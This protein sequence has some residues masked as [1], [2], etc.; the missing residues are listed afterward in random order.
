MQRN[1]EG[2]S[3]GAIIMSIATLHEMLTY[4][5]PDGSRSE[6]EFIERYL[7]PLGCKEDKFGN[8]SKSIGPAPP[9]LWSSHTDTVH[10]EDGRQSVEVSPDGWIHGTGEDCLGADC[11]AGVWLMREMIQRKVPGLYVF[12]RAEETGGRGSS[13]IAKHRAKSL[14]H[15]K[16]AI[17]LDR[18]GF[19]SIIT[20]Q[21]GGRCCSDAFASS[22]SAAMQENSWTLDTGGIFT[23]TANYTHLIGE[24]TN[25]SVGYLDQHTN[26]ERQHGPYL[27]WLLDRACEVKP[28]A[29]VY[30]RLP[31]EE[32]PDD[33]WAGYGHGWNTWDDHDRPYKPSGR[34]ALIEAIL[35][36]PGAAADL[37]TRLGYGTDDV[38]DQ[39]Y[40]TN[41]W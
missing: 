30:K 1:P 40:N 16:A 29:L 27:E 35:D 11:T 9:L 36:N 12:H 19:Q 24:C 31:G 18:K 41:A 13:Y 38:L 10:C 39:A 32:D 2:K 8:L 22:L 14:K 5:R 21:A 17:A 25:V 23:D 7:I 34:D 20:H 6:Q 33:P 3:K 26:R 4:K 28:D 15:V 37:L